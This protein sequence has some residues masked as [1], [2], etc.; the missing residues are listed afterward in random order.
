LWR[1]I[2]NGDRDRDSDKSCTY[3]KKV[4]SQ[5]DVAQLS[6]D[7]DIVILAAGAGVQKLWS[8]EDILPFAYVRGQNIELAKDD[9]NPNSIPSPNTDPNP[10][11]ELAKDDLNLLEREQRS[12]SSSLSSSDREGALEVEAESNS[13]A[14]PNSHP[15]SN[16]NPN[17]HPTSNFKPNPHPTSNSNPNPTSN[18]N[19]ELN[20]GLESVLLAGEYIVPRKRERETQDKSERVREIGSRSTLLIGGT[21]EH[22]ETMEELSAPPDIDKA[23]KLL[24]VRENART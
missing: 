14:N 24:M 21:H 22:A 15:T 12:S 3:E 23:E 9:P 11:I 8:D 10:N 2:S 19:P 16:F 7:F 1:L 20:M 4:I 17:P 18:S 13:I 5:D 6:K